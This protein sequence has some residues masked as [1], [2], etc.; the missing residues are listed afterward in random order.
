MKALHGRKKERLLTMFLTSS[1]SRILF[2][3]SSKKS[4]LI[5]KELKPLRNFHAATYIN[6]CLPELSDKLLPNLSLEKKSYDK[7]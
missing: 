2:P 5:S 7:R 6:K 4:I 3:L 1:S